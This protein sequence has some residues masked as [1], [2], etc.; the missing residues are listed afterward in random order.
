MSYDTR[1]PNYT[2]EEWCIQNNREDLLIRWDYELNKK[3]PSE[4]SY[5]SNKKF[6][7]LCPRHIHESQ[8]SN[9]QYISGGRQK[10]IICKKC[11][12]FAQYVIDNYSE[13]YLNKLSKLNLKYNLW[14]IGSK[15]NT[16]KLL[17]ECNKKGH[18]YIQTPE[19]FVKNGCQYCSHR[20]KKDDIPKEESLG[21]ICPKIIPLWSN[22]NDKTPY[23]YYPSST[24]KVYWKCENGIHE[25]F[26]RSINVS[27]MT[28][29]RCPKCVNYWGEN[30]GNW[31]GG[32]TYLDKKERQSYEYK[33]WREQVIKRDNNICQCCLK[34][35]DN[36][37]LLTHVH[38]IYNFADY[39][40]YRTNINN[41]ITLCNEC[42]DFKINDS[43]HNLYGLVHTTPKQLEEYINYKR[44]KLGITV[45]FQIDKYLIKII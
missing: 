36:H 8:L 19:N 28:D 23:S 6:Y 21:M 34:K 4:V 25:D 39:K 24:H 30:N 16:Y 38:H 9:I 35:I 15:S 13:E 26:L 27:K 1:K 43:F 10:N 40:D 45:P 22:K 18:R 42:H 31:K 29:F 44:E 17:I 14:E 5:Q 3:L 12:S 11:R 41:G 2:F 20:S 32:L 37:D 7:F 33:L